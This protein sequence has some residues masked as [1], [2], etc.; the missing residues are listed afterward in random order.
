MEYSYNPG[1][2]DCRD[3]E[4]ARAIIL[5]D[6][7]G[8]STEQRW[9]QE[10]EYLAPFL[11]ALPPGPVLDYGCGIG[12]LS[13]LLVLNHPLVVGVDIS[14]EMRQMA[15]QYVGNQAFVPIAP[16]T[17]PAVVQAGVELRS[18]IAVWALQH[19]PEWDL[20]IKQIAD[21]M[22]YDAPF[23]VVNRPNRCVPVTS[24]EPNI[25]IWVD[26]GVNLDAKLEEY[27]ALDYEE[28]IPDT[29]CHPGAYVRRYRNRQ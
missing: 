19:I 28:K 13:K 17:F 9:E 14:P 22:P 12:R 26:D 21:A 7:V 5:Q 18:A 1:I 29:L 3:E 16:Q 10:T 6:E 25:V 23:L 2:F 20:P 24:D 27:F 4:K 8:L 15:L 11:R